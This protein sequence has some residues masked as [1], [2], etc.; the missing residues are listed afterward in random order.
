MTSQNDES[1]QSAFDQMFF[2]MLE[3]DLDAFNHIFK[4][5]EAPNK[6]FLVQNDMNNQFSLL[7][8]AISVCL[9]MESMICFVRCLLESGKIDLNHIAAKNSQGPGFTAL[10]CACILSN[11]CTYQWKIIEILLAYG[12]DPNL[13]SNGFKL[14]HNGAMNHI[15]CNESLNANY[16]TD[17]DQF[18]TIV[19]CFVAAGFVL[20]T[21]SANT[22]MYGLFVK[23]IKNR[24]LIKQ[25]SGTWAN[26][27]VNRY[28]H[29]CTKDASS[30]VQGV[31][32]TILIGLASL[33]LPTLCL[34]ELV[35]GICSPYHRVLKMGKIMRVLDQV[36]KKSR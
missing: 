17:I 27:L 19:V 22:S 28:Q 13:A 4:A 11:G 35:K 30:I 9:D 16:C 1:N 26:W 36:K 3:N 8:A 5:F 34:A 14:M 21:K 31:I 20:K 23:N 7:G 15:L 29:S 2:C 25:I 6:L 10:S 18:F 12:A 33:N 24:L 32:D